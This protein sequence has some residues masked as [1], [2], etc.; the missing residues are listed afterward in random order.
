[1]ILKDI[2]DE[3]FSN[4]KSPSMLLAFPYC[5]FKC[6]KENCHNAELD[7][8]QNIETDAADVVERYLDNDITSAVVCAGLEPF[9]CFMLLYEFI[10]K[11]RQ[12]TEDMVIIYTG[13]KEK[14]IGYYL[15]LIS[16]YKNIIVK[17]GRFIPHQEPRYDEVLGVQLASSNQY[18]KQIS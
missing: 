5:N 1:M 9:Y 6:G 10:E 3:D 4:Y 18:A 11:L 8:A 14:E 16:R 15:K 13:Y 7:K 12:H 2:I 17:F